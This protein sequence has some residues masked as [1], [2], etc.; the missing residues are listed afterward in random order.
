MKVLIASR[1]LTQNRLAFY[2]KMASEY[3]KDAKKAGVED[4]SFQWGYWLGK[5]KVARVLLDTADVGEKA[6]KNIRITQRSK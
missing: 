5:A 2:K 1:R 4:A 6:G 3:R